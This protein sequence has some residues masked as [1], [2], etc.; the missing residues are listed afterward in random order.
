M[1]ENE[2]LIQGK[3]ETLDKNEIIIQRIK[4]HF[5][6]TIDSDMKIDGNIYNLGLLDYIKLFGKAA[7]RNK[8]FHIDGNSTCM[9]NCKHDGNDAIIMIFNIQQK[10]KEESTVKYS[11]EKVMNIIKWLESGFTFYEKVF[12]L[13]METGVYISV[14]KEIERD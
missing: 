10:N 4:D 6:S 7:E 11:A 14:I 1:D 5:D 2:N 13:Q 9:F 12:I 3:E 8:I